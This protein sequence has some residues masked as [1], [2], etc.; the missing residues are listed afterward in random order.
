MWEGTLLAEAGAQLRYHG[1]LDGEGIRIAAHVTATTP[2]TA[3]RMS[4]GDYLEAIRPHG[5]PAGRVTDA[6]WD[7]DLAPR[8]RKHG[9]AVFEEQVLSVLLDDMSH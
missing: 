7:P 1:D 8:V 9:I 6:P 5:P 4:A 3:W 2:A